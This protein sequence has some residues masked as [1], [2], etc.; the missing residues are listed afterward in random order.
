MATTSTD[1][2]ALIDAKV[3]LIGTIISTLSGLIANP[4]PNYSIGDQTFSWNTY[5]EMLTNSQAK[6]VESLKALYDLQ[7][8]VAPYQMTSRGI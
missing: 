2:Q 4:R 7:N 8:I 3:T 1:I 6:E 5:Y